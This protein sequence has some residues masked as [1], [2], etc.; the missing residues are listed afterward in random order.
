[1]PPPPPPPKASGCLVLA[2][3]APDGRGGVDMVPG[4][5]SDNFLGQTWLEG[6]VLLEPR[7]TV[8]FEAWPRALRRSQ[9]PCEGA[10]RAGQSRGGGVGGGRGPPAPEVPGSQP[11]ANSEFLRHEL[12]RASI[13]APAHPPLPACPHP[14][15][16]G[17]QG[18]ARP[19]QTQTH[20]S[21]NGLHPICIPPSHI[22]S[23]V[24]KGLSGGSWP[25]GIAPLPHPPGLN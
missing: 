15:Q 3:A 21:G 12:G 4:A 9:H 8:A 14:Q 16:G 10:G 18:Q 24:R 7:I 1:M 17:R 22:H 25:G 2:F 13:S 11:L 5:S 23:L 6:H 20:S 19:A